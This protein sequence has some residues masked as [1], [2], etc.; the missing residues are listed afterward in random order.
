MRRRLVFVDSQ[1]NVT[2]AVRIMVSE[3]VGSVLVRHGK[4]VI[5][6][7]TER[8]ILNRVLGKG[9][10][11]IETELRTIMSAPIL[12][13]DVDDTVENALVLMQQ[14]NCRRLLVKEKQRPAGMLVMKMI[15]GDLTREQLKGQ[16]TQSWET[17]D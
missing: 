2:L 9:L 5:G 11:P 12:A 15:T 3:K 13:I 7:V 17:Q 4:N 8:D 1:D 14:N 10:T 6:I 16:Y